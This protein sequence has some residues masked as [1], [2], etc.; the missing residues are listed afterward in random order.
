[1]VTLHVVI[2]PRGPFSSSDIDQHSTTGLGQ[3]AR[4][5]AETRVISFSMAADEGEGLPGESGEAAGGGSDGGEAGKAEEA[6]GEVTQGGH[7][8]GDRAHTGLGAIL[9]VGDVAHPMEA[10]LDGP[11]A[12]EQAEEIRGGGA[13]GGKTGDTVDDFR[14]DFTGVGSD[15]LA[16]GAEDLGEAGPVQVAGERRAGLEGALLAPPMPLVGT[17]GGRSRQV[18]GGGPLEEED[19]VRVEG[20]LVVFD[21]HQR[22]FPN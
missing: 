13:I 7:D 18:T 19:E 6:D 5:T 10:I 12:A 11:V 15:D 1:M 2:P 3:H 17:A 9:V 14:P 16:R 8:F 22:A 20:R 21:H 4:P